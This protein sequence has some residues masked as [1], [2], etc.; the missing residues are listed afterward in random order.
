MVDL[1]EKKRK[2]RAYRRFL[3][4]GN[5]LSRCQGVHQ[6]GYVSQQEKKEVVEGPAGEEG[7]SGQ[8]QGGGGSSLGVAD[9]GDTHRRRAGVGAFGATMGNWEV[10]KKRENTTFTK[11]GGQAACLLK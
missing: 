1:H 10:V 7:V 3:A 6:K 8:K 9:E 11:N 2:P 4:R 5:Q